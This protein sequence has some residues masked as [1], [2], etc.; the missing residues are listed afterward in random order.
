[1]VKV[2]GVFKN[3][4]SS[5]HKL[6]KIQIPR[7]KS[8]ILL[9]NIEDIDFF[10]QVIVDPQSPK[11]QARIQNLVDKF[12]DYKKRLIH[13]CS[14]LQISLAELPQFREK[15]S[16]LLLNLNGLTTDLEVFFEKNEGNITTKFENLQQLRKEERILSSLLL[17]QTQTEQDVF[18][19][20]LLTSS[21]STYTFLGEIPASYEELIRFYLMEITSNQAFFWSTPS[22]G[23]GYKIL[24]CITTM[25]YKNQIEEIL[26]DNYFDSTKLDLDVLKSLE[27]LSKENSIVESHQ[28]ITADIAE[29][30]QSLQNLSLNIKEQSINFLSLILKSLRILLIEE[31]G[32]TTDKDFTIWAWVKKKDYEIMI[33]EITTVLGFEPKVSILDDIPFPHKKTKQEEEE[34]IIIKPLESYEEEEALHVPHLTHRGTKAEGGFLFPQ[35]SS[36][37]KLE[38]SEKHSREF[39]SVIHSLNAIHPIKV[40]SLNKETIEKLNEQKIEL[41]QYLARIKKISEALNIQTLEVNIEEKYQL[42]DDLPH[43]KAFIENFLRDF[44]ETILKQTKEYNQLERQKEQIELYLPFEQELKERGMDVDLLEGGFQTITLLGS[45]P[46]NHY[47]AVNFFLKEVTD[48]NMLLWTSDPVSSSKNEKNILLITLKEYETPILRVLNEYSFLPIEF[49]LDIFQ[50]DVSIEE[51]KNQLEKQILESEVVL[52]ELKEQIIE[53]LVAAN[54]LIQIE[55]D[56]IQATEFCQVAENKITLWGWIPE[57]KI[58]ELNKLNEKFPAELKVTFNAKVPLVSPSITKK[59]QVFGAVRGLVGGI[60][61][62]N[63][64]EV[65]PYSIVRFTFPL[66]FGIMFADVGH[67]IM[68]ALI[69]AFLTIRKRRKKIKPDESISGYLYA[70]SEL[71]LFCGLSATIFGFLF[72]SLLGDEEFIPELMHSIGIDW[73]PLIN[74]LHETKLFLVVAL[75]L[76]FLMIQLGIWLKVY[77]KLKYGHS[78]ASWAAP[79]SLSIVYVG[80]FAL[81]YNIIAK[82]VEWQALNITLPLMPEWMVWLVAAAPILF[83][84]EFLHAKSDGIMDAIDHIIALIS[85]TLSFSR[86]MALLLVHAILSG[87]PF[88]LTGVHSPLSTAWY[89][90]IVG[91][92]VGLFIIIPIEGLLSFLNTLR[93]HWVEWF[94]K[95]YVGDGTA[96][97]PLT[98]ESDYIDFVPS[99]GS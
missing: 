8:N 97:K 48:S 44:E 37:I 27:N 29:I 80:I 67:G 94:S 14:I 43:S 77:Q 11:E 51:T 63:P 25:E 15:D 75:I 5:P 83:V 55:L 46:S 86:I 82:D 65:D 10:E 47:K 3:L 49:D 78:V 68:L 22:D 36:F 64:H 31:K 24:L 79:I 56:R 40:G 73:I 33:S 53:K 6:V 7:E 72:G 26:N 20:D 66:L 61:E 88:T 81:L 2:V 52:G 34:E 84:F 91:I 45:I 57:K 54:E 93:L 35:K 87:L 17:F 41:N 58:K 92:L 23:S 9:S 59:G 39:I 19:V 16:S 69:A 1:M 71:L 18:S 98:E 28:K 85:N 30:E 74:P 90:W 99:K 76:G 42:V 21:S 50:Q 62:P 32:R 12:K 96:Y 60:G 4:V 95:F 89:W 70:G 38:S 13:F